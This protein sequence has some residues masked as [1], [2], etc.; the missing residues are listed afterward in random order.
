M[1]YIRIEKAEQLRGQK[2]LLKSQIEILTIM[3]R[4]QQFKK[5]RKQELM[6]KTA[7]K[8]AL[9]EINE[10]MKIIE[11]TLPHVKRHKTESEKISTKIPDKVRQDL[12][13]E[14]M[15]IKSKLAS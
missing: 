15:D 7:F 11:R 5:L 6:M 3:K 2:E 14:I 1:E 4:Y 9:S 10:H 12:E 8:R 13:Q